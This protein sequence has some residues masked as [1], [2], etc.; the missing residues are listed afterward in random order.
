MNI[1]IKNLMIPLLVFFFFGYK[2]ESGF[3]SAVAQQDR[4]SAAA[5]SMNQA[6]GRVLAPV[7]PYLARYIADTFDLHKKSG[8]G[9]DIGGGPGNLVSE[10]CRY[11][12]NMY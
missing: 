4:D 5:A 10:L 2:A 3:S 11:T 9:I 7:Y 6:A 8:I 1:L 12:V